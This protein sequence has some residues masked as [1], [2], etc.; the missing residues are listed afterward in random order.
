MCGII[1][2]GWPSEEYLTKSLSV[3]SHR[4]PDDEG[5]FIDDFVSLGHKRLSILDLSER[6][7]QPMSKLKYTITFNGEIYNFNEIKKELSE[8]NFETT[9]D[10]EVIIYAYDKWKYECLEKFNGMF[11]F[12]IY[13]HE[14]KELFLA[15]DRFGI[16][17]LY[18]INE[19]NIVF[20]SEIKGLLHFLD[21]KE[22]DHDGLLQFFNF[23]F[24]LGETTL[25]KNIKKFLPGHYMVYSLTEN[26]VK[27]YCRYYFLKTHEKEKKPFSFYSNKL[28][29]LIEEAVKRRMVADVPVACFLSGG[30]DSSVIAAIAKKYNENLNTFSIGFD[31]TN[32]LSY[33]KT[34]SDHIHSRHFEFK[35]DKSNVLDYLQDMVWHMDEPIGDPGFL[36]IFVLSKEASKYNKVVLSGDGADEVLCGYDRYKFLFYGGYLNHLIFFDSKND[37]IKRLKRMRNKDDYESFFEII[38]LFDDSELERLSLS[39]YNAKQF[40]KNSFD[41]SVSNA[42]LFDIETLLPNDFFMKAD[43]MSSAFGLE[44]RVPF[45]DYEVVE[46]AFSIPFNYKLRFW[47]EKYIL[48]KS[49]EKI[50]P[51]ITVKR[52]K[53]G[54]NV[55]FDYWFKGV[56][57]DLLNEYL[58]KEN[59]GLYNREYVFE[60]L[61]LIKNAGNNYKL[62][63]ILAQKLWSILIFEMWYEKYLN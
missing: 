6:G 63:F 20:C 25:L 8:Y 36:P 55:P 16:K 44:Q 40:W 27:K 50:L 4:G 51:P 5:I 48:K 1:G 15:R 53:H 32:E 57:G 37:I 12:C 43:K 39:N 58:V 47:N 49:F 9:S 29:E 56:L 42:Q 54:F 31:T 30:V 52:R 13:D 45:L 21:K 22:I 35:I 17:P 46:F 23:R 24:T 38:R 19:N 34:V 11:S 3:I 28:E 62:N 10:T 60:L 59:H 26:K 61:N 33:A 7:R 14:S 18:Y 2:F 41:N